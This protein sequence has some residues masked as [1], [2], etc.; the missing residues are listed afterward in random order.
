MSFE[1]LK[2]LTDLTDSDLEFLTQKCFSEAEEVEGHVFYKGVDWGT[3][4]KI[5]LIFRNTR[6]QM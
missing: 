4:A 5:T 2:E 1:S 3:Y 6:Y